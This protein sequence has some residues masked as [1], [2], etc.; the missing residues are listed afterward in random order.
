M[1]RGLDRALERAA[2]VAGGILGGYRRPEHRT[3]VVVQPETDAQS[4]SATA[5]VHDVP[6]GHSGPDQRPVGVLPPILPRFRPAPPPPGGE[7]PADQPGLGPLPEPQ[8]WTSL[9][10]S[11]PSR[12]VRPGRTPR[13]AAARSHLLVGSVVAVLVAVALA[14]FWLVELHP[15]ISQASLE[16]DVAAR[17]GAPTVHCVSAKTNGA[18]WTCGIVYGAESVCDLANVSVFGSWKT[19]AADSRRCTGEP[20]LIGMAPK[21][22]AA[23]VKVALQHDYGVAV[24]AC[25]RALGYHNRWDCLGRTGS[26]QFTCTLVRAVA[27]TPFNNS[28]IS[29]KDCAKVPALRRYMG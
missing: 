25:A 24:Q 16:R 4:Y 6:A 23:G 21:V 12:S 27:W 26:G 19:V 1:G 28:T 7:P 20:A 3:D 17:T 15:R 14:A 5:V 29:V 9:P 13:R 8:I 10:A 22:T 18:V 11:V 2:E